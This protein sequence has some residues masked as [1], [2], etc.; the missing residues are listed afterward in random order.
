MSKRRRR[1]R[2]SSILPF[3][4]IAVGLLITLA[5]VILVLDPF[6]NGDQGELAGAPEA[7]IPFPDVPRVS[8][9]DAKAAYDTEQAIFVDVRGEPFYSDAHIP[10]ALSITEA[11]LDT[12]VS[13]FEPSDWII[14]Y[15]T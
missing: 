7:G 5:A 1:S 13:E 15:C 14:T 4:V 11:Q 9:G 10:G 6:G 2:S 3:V 8:L 12:A